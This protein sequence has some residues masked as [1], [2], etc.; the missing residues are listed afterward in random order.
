VLLLA[1]AARWRRGEL[2]AGSDRGVL[3]RD[4]ETRLRACGVVRPDRLAAVLTE[5]GVS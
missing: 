3:Q 4:A 1:V 2:Q 5:G